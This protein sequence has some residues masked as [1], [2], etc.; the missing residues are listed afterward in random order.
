MTD[1]VHQTDEV[2]QIRQL[3]LQLC[4]QTENYHDLTLVH[5]SAVT[6]KSVYWLQDHVFPPPRWPTL[7]DAW[8]RERF[9]QAMDTLY[10]SPPP[11]QHF[12]PHPIPTPACIS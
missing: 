1:E 12:S 6:G 3:A 10:K 8:P 4:A 7:R 5:L 11:P 9:Q 2:E